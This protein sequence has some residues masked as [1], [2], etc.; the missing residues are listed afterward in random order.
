MNVDD[1]LCRF[2]VSGGTEDL[3]CPEKNDS[4]GYQQA[5]SGAVLPKVQL[6]QNH[7]LLARLEGERRFLM[8]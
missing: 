6:D 5:C 1:R 8:N 4:A 3:L 7:S 2:C